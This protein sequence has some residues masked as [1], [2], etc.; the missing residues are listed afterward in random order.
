MLRIARQGRGPGEV[1]PPRDYA[2]LSRTGRTRDWLVLL[3]DTLVFLDGNSMHAYSPEG[4]HI[5]S[6]SLPKELSAERTL[7]PRRTTRVRAFGKGVVLDIASLL[8]SPGDQT[9][10]AEQFYTLW[11]V[12]DSTAV[13]LARRPLLPPPQTER[14]ALV[15]SG[16][17]ARPMYDLLGRCAV[18]SDGG[19]PQLQVISLDQ[20]RSEELRVHYSFRDAAP[21]PEEEAVRRASGASGAVPP[22]SLPARIVNLI[23]DPDGWIWLEP[24]QPPGLLPSLE[25]VRLN[26]ISGQERVDT[27]P[28]FPRAFL[29]GGR[30][31][32]IELD[33]AGIP[34]IRVASTSNAL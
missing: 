21:D 14:G 10:A 16:L 32:T 9:Q 4:R 29:G 34:I 11:L 17:E 25:V 19:N 7:Y 27:V 18:V 13:R 20:K 30:F 28:F 5:R 31:M 6:R 1:V 24:V 15:F 3:G 22:P 2:V 12:T 8:H 33:S 26:A 23:T